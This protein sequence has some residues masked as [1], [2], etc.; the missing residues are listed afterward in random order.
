[1]VNS[2]ASFDKVEFDNV[3]AFSL[4]TANNSSVF[5]NLLTFSSFNSVHPFKFTASSSLTIENSLFFSSFTSILFYFKNSNLSLINT[6]LINMTTQSVLITEAAIIHLYNMKIQDTFVFDVFS[7][8]LDTNVQV[9]NPIVRNSQFVEMF[10]VIQS[11]VD[12]YS[13]DFGSTNSLTNSLFNVSLSTVNV[14]D[15]NVSGPFNS[16]LPLIQVLNSNFTISQ[17]NASHLNTPL[18]S[19]YSSFTLWNDVIVL[20]STADFLVSVDFSNSSFSN[21]EISNSVIN[22]DTFW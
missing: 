15:I 18:F 7:K 13:I 22:N 5:T 16:N 3:T 2:S 4:F 12:L 1:M 19:C 10:Q 11:R 8:L 14:H 20:N 9:E 17:F 6:E 21:V